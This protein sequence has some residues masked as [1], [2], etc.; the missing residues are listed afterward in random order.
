[1][2]ARGQGHRDQLIRSVRTTADDKI[3]NGRNRFGFISASGRG[4]QY[5]MTE[6]FFGSRRRNQLVGVL[7]VL[8]CLVFSAECGDV[9]KIGVG[10]ADITGPAAEINMVSRGNIY[11]LACQKS[12]TFSI[13]RV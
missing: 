11:F 1:M 4:K 8:C 12:K 7:G 9:Y 5:K 6:E 3:N 13:N 2:T 10:I